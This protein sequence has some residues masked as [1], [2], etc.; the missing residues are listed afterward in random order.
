VTAVSSLA[1]VDRDTPLIRWVEDMHSRLTTETDAT[2]SCD[3][4]LPAFVDPEAHETKSYPFRRIAWQP[5][6]STNQIVH[7]GILAARENPWRP[8]DLKLLQR[9]AGVYSH[10]WQALRGARTFRPPQNRQRAMWAAALAAVAVTCIIPV[11]MTTLAPV[12]IVAREPQLVTA[13]IDGVIQTIAIEP[14][15]QVAAGTELLRYDD[16]VL[17][18]RFEIADQEMRVARVRFERTQQA[19]L[20]DSKARHELLIAETEYELKKAERD[21]AASLRAKTVV[22]AG[23][24]GLL[25]YTSRDDWIGRPVTTG[26]KIMSIATPSRVLA[27]IELPVADAITLTGNAR[28]RLFLDATP[29]DARPARVVNESYHAAPNASQQLVYTLHAELEE[30][31]AATNGQEPAMAQPRIGARG[32]AQVFGTTV[33]LIF[34]LLRRPISYLRQSLG[35]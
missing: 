3:F 32:T 24:S 20:H 11:P 6:A 12:E 29:L 25:I 21:H 2:A 26:Q 1:L 9:Q 34:F 30:S 19:A 14:N 27:R 15:R 22:H 33:P 17:K 7:A 28:V 16:T 10:A 8:D 35:F 13:P 4:S 18:N 23:Q 5:M 31:R